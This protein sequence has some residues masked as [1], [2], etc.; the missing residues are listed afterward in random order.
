MLYEGP[1]CDFAADGGEMALPRPR[2]GPVD[3]VFRDRFGSMHVDLAGDRERRLALEYLEFVS[4]LA[5]R[6]G[7]LDIHR[8]FR[9]Y[10]LDR[11]RQRLHDL[12][13]ARIVYPE[14]YSHWED[15]GRGQDWWGPENLLLTPE[16]ERLNRVVFSSDTLYR[17]HLSHN[18]RG[19]PHAVPLSA[20]AGT[21]PG[22]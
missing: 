19:F 17:F 1:P 7:L 20:P 11:F 8:Q 15:Y 2:E 4:F 18:D 21:V 14:A 12:P 6:G 3:V 9:R 13:P 10:H 22:V 5:A 16:M